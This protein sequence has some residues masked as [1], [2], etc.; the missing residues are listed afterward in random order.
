MAAHHNPT[1]ALSL[2]PPSHSSLAPQGIV[3]KSGKGGQLHSRKGLGRHD[4]NH[5][6]GTGSMTDPKG[7]LWG[8]G[9]SP[10]HLCLSLSPFCL[11]LPSL[12]VS[13]ASL[14]LLPPSLSVSFSQAD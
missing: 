6:S 3:G 10:P 5:F 13:P 1:L 7:Q 2:L 4:Q 9:T 11:S 8:R 12:S 14:S